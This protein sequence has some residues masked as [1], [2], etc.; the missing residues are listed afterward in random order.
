MKMTIEI[1]NEKIIDF[2]LKDVLHTLRLYLNLI[3]ISKIYRLDLNNVFGAKDIVAKFKDGKT[4]IQEV[5]YNRLYLVRV[6]Y[7]FLILNTKSVE[8]VVSLEN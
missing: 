1:E 4:A 7:E 2:I 6:I 3:F 8:K 5:C